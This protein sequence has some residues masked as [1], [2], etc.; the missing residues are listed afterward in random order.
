[1]EILYHFRTGNAIMNI[2]RSSA[3][4]GALGKCFFSN[5]AQNFI[6]IFVKIAQRRKNISISRVLF[7]FELAF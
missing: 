2:C 4:G 5:F 3:R 1:M 7:D 6:A